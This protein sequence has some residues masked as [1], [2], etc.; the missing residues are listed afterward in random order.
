MMKNTEKSTLMEYTA[1]S[2]LK[3]GFKNE[4]KTNIFAVDLNW[5]VNYPPVEHVCI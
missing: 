1:K 5:Q 3:V 4:L 2:N